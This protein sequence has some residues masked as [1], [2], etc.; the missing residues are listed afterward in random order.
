MT[1]LEPAQPIGSA[2]AITDAEKTGKA[3]NVFV[4][5]TTGCP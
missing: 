3:F 1:G 4:V 2:G 5:R